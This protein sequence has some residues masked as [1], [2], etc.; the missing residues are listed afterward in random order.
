MLSPWFCR[1]V[2][3]T[4]TLI[5]LYGT[6]PC[7]G[8]IVLEIPDQWVDSFNPCL[9]SISCCGN[10]LKCW[11]F[12]RE[13]AHHPASLCWGWRGGP[14]PSTCAHLA[15]DDLVIPLYL[16]DIA[17]P[18][19]HS[20]PGTMVAV[21]ARAVERSIVHRQLRAVGGLTRKVHTAGEERN[22]R[23]RGSFPAGSQYTSWEIKVQGIP[24][25]NFRRLR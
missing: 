9:Q 21:A 20:T 8:T 18:A 16:E 14:E 24:I 1:F 19:A 17:G 7:T 11:G 15:L 3:L 5:Q 10:S 25:Q 13:H 12:S 22:R 23:V 4:K 2:T 6:L